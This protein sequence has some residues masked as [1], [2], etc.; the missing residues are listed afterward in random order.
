MDRR[1][2]LVVT[3]AVL[4]ALIGVWAT[5]LDEAGL[6]A[7]R[8]GAWRAV[9]G[10]ACFVAHAAAT[11]RLRPARELRPAPVAALALVGVSLFYVAL[12]AAASE[13]GVSLAWVLLY[14]APAFVA[15]GSWLWLGEGLGAGGVALVVLTLLG[16]ALVVL[17][18]SEGIT[19][20]TISVSWGLAAGFGYAAYTLLTKSL[21]SDAEPV[22]VL[23][24][25]LPLGAVPLLP[26]LGVPSGLRVWALLVGLGIVSTYLP[27]LAYSTALRHVPASRASIV[28]SVEPLVAVAIAVLV[29][30]ESLHPVALLGAALIIGAAAAAVAQSA[31]AAKPAST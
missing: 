19:I 25:A 14:T 30:G 4:W 8:I 7:V 15:V 2:L 10:G 9:L 22:T 31:R 13:G 26:V 12:P 23:A 18:D 21:S 1:Y 27:Y 28:A 29:Y 11:G 6:S 16:V 17:P 5:E 24:V 20:S 3:A